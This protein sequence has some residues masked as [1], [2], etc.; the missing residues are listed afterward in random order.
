[1]HIPQW[2]PKFDDWKPGDPFNL[3]PP[4]PK[5]ILNPKYS[6][7]LPAETR[8][9]IQEEYGYYSARRAEAMV[10]PR[11]GPTAA[12]RAAARMWEG[13][14]TVYNIPERK[15]TAVAEEEE[16]AISPTVRARGRKKAGEPGAVVSTF[17]LTTDMEETLLDDRT[18]EKHWMSA[19]QLV[20]LAK[21]IENKS[22]SLQN[23]ELWLSQVKSRNPNLP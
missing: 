16:E 9:K 20:E 6:P 7:W 10:P 2:P 23:A 14:R 17:P 8:Q 13:L 11:A 1:M 5:F 21:D 12:R 18:A 15:G 3:E 19:Q 4:I 22:I